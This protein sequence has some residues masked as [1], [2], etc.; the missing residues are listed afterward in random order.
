M[1]CTQKTFWSLHTSQEA[2][3]I[4]LELSYPDTLCVGKILLFGVL[5]VVFYLSLLLCSK[6]IRFQCISKPDSNLEVP[7]RESLKISNTCNWASS[8]ES[9]F[10]QTESRPA[11]P[12]IYWNSNVCEELC[13]PLTKFFLIVW[14]GCG[15][16]FNVFRSF[17]M[18]IKQSSR[19]K[20]WVSFNHFQ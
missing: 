4:T 10:C 17:G 13:F 15:F 18:M 11:Y 5:F 6:E 8:V 20:N 7:L 16:A 19:Q 1:I 12:H 14:I 3:K 2:Q 9:G